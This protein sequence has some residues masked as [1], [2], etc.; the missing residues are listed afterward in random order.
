MSIDLSDADYELLERYFDTVLERHRSG[1]WDA[2]RARGDL[3]EAFTLLSSG[4]L[5]RNHMRNVIDDPRI[6]D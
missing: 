1:R 2:A 6:A 3:M 4:V 5:F